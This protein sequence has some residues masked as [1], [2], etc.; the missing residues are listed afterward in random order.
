MRSRG[1]FKRRRPT[2]AGLIQSSRRSYVAATR[3]QM[4]AL[5]LV[6][7][8]TRSCPCTKG[9]EWRPRCIC[10]DYG[11]LTAKSIFK[12]VMR[13][14][15]CG[16]G[17]KFGNCYN[18][19]HIKALHVRSSMYE[20]MGRP[21]FAEEDAEWILELAPRL[22]DGYLRLGNIAQQYGNDEYAWN[23][24][25][26]GL[27]ANKETPVDSSPKLQQLFDAHKP[28]HWHFS[29]R[30]PLVLLP[31]MVTHIFSYLHFLELPVCLRVCKK[32]NSTLTR[33]PHCELWR[34]MMFTVDY[35]ERATRLADIK[36]L[37]T[38]A[39]TGGARKIEIALG[40]MLTQAALTLLLKASTRLEHLEIRQ[41]QGLTLPLRENRWK[42]LRHVAIESYTGFHD[43]DVDGPGGLP[44]AFIQN[45]A[46]SLEHL[47]LVGIPPQWYRG[48]PGLPS[49]PNLKTLRMG[50]HDENDAD[51]YG[52]GELVDY[53][54]IPA[55]F[56]IL[57]LSMAFPKL[58]QLC[59]GPDVSYLKPDISTSGQGGWDWPCMFS[60]SYDPFP[61]FNV[62][63]GSEFQN[64]RSFN[65]QKLCMSPD[66]AKTLLSNA[67]KSNQLTSFDIVFPDRND[68]DGHLKG[69]EWLCGSP[70]IQ[71]LGCYRYRFPLGLE[72]GDDLLLPQFLATFPNLRTLRIKLY[73]SSE[74]CQLVKVLLPSFRVTHL[75]T[76]YTS[77]YEDKFVARLRQ[78]AQGYGVKLI[79]NSPHSEG[80]SHLYGARPHQWP[81]PL[82]ALGG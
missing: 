76:I 11:G 30:D 45:A 70:S 55:P 23:V 82:S 61:D 68:A 39:G 40:A 41:L 2:M 49:L 63:Q 75:K 47:D 3:K 77:V 71:T 9:V 33:S 18:M 78:V 15:E 7:K 26:A 38:W 43:I 22:P 27:E 59:I 14:C 72:N 34:N 44:Q 6:T 13:T 19:Q 57:P 80:Q 65:S 16:V 53:D 28:L 37:L 8:A 20:A 5:I 50:D 66:G 29:R 25:S 56:P 32:W 36:R 74:S 31:E 46:S 69:Y 58:E 10:K 79:N 4:R 67:V 51:D 48:L 42:R 21:D 54:N 17:E 24:Y 1:A 35:A 64:L 60:D 52:M 81:I 12:E 73:S 62:N